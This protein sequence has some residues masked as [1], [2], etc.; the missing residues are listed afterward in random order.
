MVKFI[1]WLIDRWLRRSIKEA[2]KPY[3]SNA[4]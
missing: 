3:G 4:Q 2:R 1:H